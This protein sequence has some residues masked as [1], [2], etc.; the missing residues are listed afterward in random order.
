[1]PLLE[2]LVP[3]LLVL[4]ALLGV[5]ALAG[6]GV[7][8]GD[9]VVGGR[10][11]LLLLVGVGVAG[12]GHGRL[13]VVPGAAESAARGGVPRR[14]LGARGAGEGRP[15]AGPRGRR[16]RHSPGGGDLEQL[17]VPL[18]HGRLL[19]RSAVAAAV[20]DL[21]T[22]DRRRRVG[23]GAGGIGVQSAESVV[24]SGREDCEVRG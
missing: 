13:A 2:L 4:N 15:G 11:L 20:G 1:M 9:D 21:E 5:D 17:G 10:R 12:Q 22:G 7:A 23:V 3:A 14:Q 8:G 24:R 16:R 18:G 19:G 6:A